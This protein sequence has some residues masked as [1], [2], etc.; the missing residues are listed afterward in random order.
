MHRIDIKND[1]DSDEKNKSIIK[2]IIDQNT[3]KQNIKLETLPF[4][5]RFRP[6]TLDGIM[7]HRET[8][9]ILKK[10]LKTHNIPHL[11]F[12]GPPGTGKTSTVE[13]FV[14]ELYGHDNVPFMTMNIN[15]SEKRGIEIVRKE[16]KNFITTLSL[17]TTKNNSPSYKFVILD[18]ADAMTAE[19]QG[20]LKQLIESNTDNARFCL[21]CNCNKK[22]HPAIQSRCTNFNFP[23][24]DFNS[25]VKKIKIVSAEIGVD[26]TKNGMQTMWKLSNGDMRKVLYMIQVIS[27]NNKLIDSDT[28]TNFRNY[29]SAMVVA[30][31][32]KMLLTKSLKE[33]YTYT[34]KLF[35]ETHYSLSDMMIELVDCITSDIIT[36]KISSDR[37]AN[38]LL[39]LRD[40]EMNIIVTT[41]TNMQMSSLVSSF[42]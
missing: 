37:G 5:E 15:A 23:P 40:I 36:K 18:E 10:F 41:D 12:Y 34:V 33:S 14:K 6:N 8:V 25:V 31:L 29:P 17:C 30:E 2:E 11:L 1:V 39:K 3:A 35:K 26:I 7:T 24:L 38:I 22:I 16:I 4:V 9:Q 19:A 20:M 21:I 27:I 28:I 42:H 13:A 32:Y